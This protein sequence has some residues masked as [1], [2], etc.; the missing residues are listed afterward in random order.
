MYGIFLVP[1]SVP[2]FLKH[3]R[4]SPFTTLGDRPKGGV[5]ESVT[6]LRPRMNREMAEHQAAPVSWP[7]VFAAHSP[8]R[9]DLSKSAASPS[10]LS[11]RK[12]P[13]SLPAAVLFPGA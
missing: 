8:L 13:Y 7:E 12:Q 10:L 1:C 11:P 2:P 6:A 4:S 3:G 5:E 9:K